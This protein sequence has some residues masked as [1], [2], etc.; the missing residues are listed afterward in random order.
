MIA[1]NFEE[2]IAAQL[3][4]RQL[5]FTI[6]ETDTHYFGNAY[7]SWL[8]RIKSENLPPIKPASEVTPIFNNVS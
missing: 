2:L 3:I 5:K 1:D 7:E 4:G 8:K 6:R